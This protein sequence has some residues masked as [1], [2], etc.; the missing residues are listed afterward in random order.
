MPRL[1]TANFENV[2]MSA[3]QDLFEVK[4][5]SGKVVRI[6]RC[7]LGLTPTTLA[8]AQSLRTQCRF[9]PATVTDGSGGT[10][11]TFRRLD[12]GD[13]AASAT[14]LANNT[15]QAS[16]NGT[17]AVLATSGDHIYAGVVYDFQ[18]MKAVPIIGASEAFTFE[19]LS[20]VSG[21]VAMSGGVLIEELAG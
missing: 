21:T 14:V 10:T 6:L 1:Y 11:P 4:G 13:A 15:S 8:T 20:T 2:S 3:A 17:A 19:L 7:W 16:T 18:M 5:A 12:V 9:L